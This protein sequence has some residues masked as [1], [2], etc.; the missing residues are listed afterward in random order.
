MVVLKNRPKVA[1]SRVM[2][3]MTWKVMERMGRMP[4]PLVGMQSLHPHLA[5][6]TMT[7]Q[8]MGLM[9]WQPMPLVGMQSLHPHLASESMTWQVMGL[10]GRLPMLL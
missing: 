7:W 9:G 1:F 5:S 10:M 3:V 6:E 4:M 8:V 2:H